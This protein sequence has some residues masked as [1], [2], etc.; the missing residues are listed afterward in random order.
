MKKTVYLLAAVLLA[1]C[2]GL[3]QAQV[4]EKL[5]VSVTSMG[6]ATAKADLAIVFLTVRSTAP[7]AADALTQNNKKLEE[8]KAR[9]AALGYKDDKIKFSGNRFAPAGGGVYYGGQRPTGFDVYNFVDV[10]LDGPELRDLNQLNARVSNLLDELGKVGASPYDLPISR[11]SMGGSS[12]VAFTVK[13]PSAYE[14][15]ASL[16]AME[17]ARSIAEDIARTMKAQI[18]GID[19]ISSRA[20][21]GVVQ[22]PAASPL[23]D[24]PYQYYS[25]SVDE[26]PIRVTLAI[27]YTIK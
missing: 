20:A 15:Q 1:V 22:G 17:A 18:T 12:I 10:F 9:L 19:S 25:S 5:V 24:L 27:S 16:Q 2:R 14:K 21:P 13:D 3:S 26:V 4:P 11:V 6:K 8:V 23:E 7:L